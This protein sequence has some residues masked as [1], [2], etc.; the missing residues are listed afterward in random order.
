MADDNGL[1]AD[2]ESDIVNILSAVTLSGETVFRTVDNWKFQLVNAD[3]FRAYS[4]FAFVEYAGTSRY[5]WEGDHELGQR[6]LFTIRVG[7]EIV[8][9][10]DGAAR[11]GIGTSAAAADK[12]L[13]ISRLRDL[14]IAALQNVHATT[15]DVHVEHYEYLSDDL[16]WSLPD[17]AALM[18]KFQV[19]RVY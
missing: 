17:Q 5:G 4:P 14:V 16:I 11:I 2:I 9:G 18:M 7:T 6:L 3:S 13:G 19:D 15:T 12:Q 8:V 1:V 10:H